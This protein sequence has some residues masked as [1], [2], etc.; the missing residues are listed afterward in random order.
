[1]VCCFS[2]SSKLCLC[3]L[4]RKRTFSSVDTVGSLCSFCYV[5]VNRNVHRK[6]C[7]MPASPSSYYC[8]YHGHLGWVEGGLA[9][10]TKRGKQKFFD[11]LCIFIRGCLIKQSFACELDV[12][13]RL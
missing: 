8:T 7:E 9:K 4:K 3:E 1:M 13:C 6:G 5:R 12:L 10:G 2:N 11:K